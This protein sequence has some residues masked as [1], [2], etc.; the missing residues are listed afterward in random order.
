MNQPVLCR[1]LA[2][3][4]LIGFFSASPAKASEPPRPTVAVVLA[5]GG[6]LGFAHV[7]VLE[8]I[9]ALGIP[10]DIVAGTSIGSI[11]GA[12][13]AAGY[14]ADQMVA[15]TETTD[16]NEVLFDAPDRLQLGY[17]DRRQRRAF[18][19]SIK[20]REGEL[21]LPSG[22]SSAQRVV[23]YLDDLLRA[24]ALTDSFLD[25]PRQLAIVAAD[26]LTGE[27]VVF[28]EG[29]LK[30]AIRA[31]FSVPGA[32]N[33]VYYQGRYLVDGGIIN[34]VPVDVARNLG[35]DIVI[36]VNLSAM[37]NK[38]E[39]LR[40]ISNILDQSMLIMRK[41]MLDEH[42]A[43]SDLIISPDVEGLGPAD[44]S[45]ASL[46]IQRGR[47]AAQNQWDELEQ[48]AL[49]IRKTRGF[50][51]PLTSRPEADQPLRIGSAR[52]EVPPIILES[53]RQFN[54]GAYLLLEELVESLAGTETTVS[55]L[56]EA[57]YGLYHTGLFR[58]ISYDVTGGSEVMILASPEEIPSS[59][60]SVGVGLRGQLIEN[61][62]GMAMTHLRY[63]YDPGDGAPRWI[64]EGW[65]ARSTSLRAALERPVTPWFFITPAVYALAENMPF[66][67]GRSVESF[68]LRRRFG[69]ELG[70]SARISKNWQFR[71]AAFAE[72]L[73]LQRLEGS[74]ID[75]FDF[76]GSARYGGRFEFDRD[77]L[78]RDLFPRRGSETRIAH[79]IHWD[80]EQEKFVHLGTLSAR[81][82][83]TPLRHVTL[84]MLARGGSDSSTGAAVYE[85]FFLG[86]VENWYGYYYHELQ[87]RHFAVAGADGRLAVGRL[88]LG[89]GDRIYLVAGGQYGG[90]HSEQPE[91]FRE[92]AD[93]R[94]GLHAGLALNTILGA[95][96]IGTAVNSEGR[97]MT[98]IELG[99][100]YTMEGTGYDW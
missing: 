67:D 13:Y 29:D 9:E 70:V 55:G 22:M 21:L 1:I 99:P 59:S 87:A 92:D 80:E 74:R 53:T 19:G 60:L 48:L 51:E 49:E 96:H 7:G 18:R 26:L 31:S 100:A 72:W 20:F 42:L 3:G 10:V 78:D 95:L 56:Q 81:R 94:W 25:L 86:G 11:V 27:Q 66:Y 90:I 41:E 15:I 97:V 84:Q 75:E 91:T 45:Q 77:T 17:T 32:F 89:V 79:R 33:P 4:L 57:V 8:A 71:A 34:N 24:Q 88:P 61:S 5:G 47:E 58:S 50:P 43:L 36:T 14:R 69:A 98:F 83:W 2:I 37:R 63:T 16:W 39:E 93:Y 44:F 65:L 40:S 76:E 30:T 73:T 12:F 38:P 64:L 6:A 68:Y 23:E 62:L 35:A 28:T 46:L 54:P 82:Y 52:Y 85:R